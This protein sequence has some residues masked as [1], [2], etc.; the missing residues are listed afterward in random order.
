M[1]ERLNRIEAQQ[2]TNI[3][4]IADLITLSESVLRAAEINLA[5]IATLFE[6]ASDSGDRFNILISEM[7]ADRRTSQQAFRALLLQLANLN[8]RVDDLEQAG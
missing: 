7:R 1:T 4:N 8:G 6:Q 3:A 2:E 5:A